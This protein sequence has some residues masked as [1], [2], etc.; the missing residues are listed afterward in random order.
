MNL[1]NSDLI[2][3]NLQNQFVTISDQFLI[4]LRPKFFG[5][6]TFSISLMVEIIKWFRYFENKSDIENI[7]ST[8]GFVSGDKQLLTIYCYTSDE[9]VL[10]QI[11][12]YSLSN[13]I[14]IQS[15]KIIDD[16]FF[17]KKLHRKQKVI[18]KGPWYGKYQ[19]RIRW[20]RK[21][22]FQKKSEILVNLKQFSGSYLF[23]N[24]RPEILYVENA[25]DAIFIKILYG[26][27]ITEINDASNV[28]P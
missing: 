7:I 13:D 24:N 8:Q 11:L 2:H 21:T 18:P 1:Y 4:V 6:Y 9:N 3:S 26:R 22:F 17:D 14:F 5:Q 23:N 20:D 27:D 15:V 12:Q 10:N 16:A 28:R 25:N 19:Y